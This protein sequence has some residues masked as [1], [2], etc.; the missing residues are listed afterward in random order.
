MCLCACLLGIHAN[1]WTQGH[2]AVAA[3][4]CLCQIW[5]L[6]NNI[7]RKRHIKSLRFRYAKS[8]LTT[9]VVRMLF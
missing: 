1:G 2:E 9:E 7:C 3:L 4:L 6:T 5:Q 8:D